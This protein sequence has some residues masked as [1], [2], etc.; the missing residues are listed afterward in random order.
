MASVPP[1]GSSTRLRTASARDRLSAM[2]GACHSMCTGLMSLHCC[3]RAPWCARHHGGGACACAG[4]LPP[5]HSAALQ[6]AP[7]DTHAER[8][9]ESVYL[10]PCCVRMPSLTILSQSAL[11]FR[12]SHAMRSGRSSGTPVASNIESSD[13]ACGIPVTLSKISSRTSHSSCESYSASDAN[14]LKRCPTQ[15][16]PYIVSGSNWQAH[17]C[18][19]TGQRAWALHPAPDLWLLLHLFLVARPGAARRGFSQL[20]P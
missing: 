16:E 9:F 18:Q 6:R 12:R 14:A 8:S 7:S 20:H 19:A 13:K 15:V 17:S 5:A 2:C 11:N 4:A 3:M 10:E 1:V